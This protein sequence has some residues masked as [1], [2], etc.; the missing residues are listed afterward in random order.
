MRLEA[1]LFVILSHV[2]VVRSSRGRD[3]LHHEEFITDPYSR[4]SHATDPHTL[5]GT[6]P[7]FTLAMLA[8]TAQ[9]KIILMQCTIL[10][11]LRTTHT[12]DKYKTTLM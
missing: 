8:G 12:W 2:C 7:I 4:A 3:V 10:Q 9:S 1:V 11:L 6:G 5:V